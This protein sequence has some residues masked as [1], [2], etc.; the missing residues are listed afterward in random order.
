MNIAKVLMDTTP[1]DET[2]FTEW[3]VSKVVAVET[4]VKY[5]Y[6]LGK[7]LACDVMVANGDEQAIGAELADIRGMLKSLEGKQGAKC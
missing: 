5:F 3:E 7:N 4:A 2:D 1:A 6:W